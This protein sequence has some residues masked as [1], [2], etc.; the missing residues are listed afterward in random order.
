MESI[1]GPQSSAARQDARA[2]KR[3]G[4][5]IRPWLQGKICIVSYSAMFPMFVL[6]ALLFYL[7][8]R[9]HLLFIPQRRHPPIVRL[10]I[11]RGARLLFWVLQKIGLARVQI[12][13][14]RGP[15]GAVV[16]IAN[17]PS[18]LDAMLLL[19]AL[20]NAVCIM[21]RPLL[22]LPIIG[23]F[24]RR[25][26]YIPQTEA[27]ELL[28]AAKEVLATGASI[29]VFPEGTRSTEEGMGRFKRGAARLALEARCPIIP[30]AILMEPVVL[31]RKWPFEHP[32]GA[33]IQYNATRLTPADSE[34]ASF[35]GLPTEGL[36]AES[37]RL[38]RYLEERIRN[39]LL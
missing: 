12:D 38:T 32:P 15:S 10:Y 13:L 11:H 1:T 20:P 37:E 14:T 39:S 35:T 24:A 23:G 34:C 33:V 4:W 26:H 19:S 18:M 16:V 9:C 8:M 27:P 36:R 22:R 29:I 21:K 7:V 5:A 6:G 25:A 3:G 2:Q 31:G 28:Q 17:H 30:I